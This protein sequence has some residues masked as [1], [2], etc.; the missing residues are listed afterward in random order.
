MASLDLSGDGSLQLSEFPPINV[1]KDKMSALLKE[2][3]RLL[4][5]FTANQK[6]A[7]L[8]PKKLKK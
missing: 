4:A 7:A 2:E 5:Q 8:V 3:N 6:Q 1:L